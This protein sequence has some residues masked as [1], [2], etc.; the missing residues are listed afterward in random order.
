[1]RRTRVC[2]LI[3]ACLTVAPLGGCLSGGQMFAIGMGVAEQLAETQITGMTAEDLAEHR[4]LVSDVHK[5]V[6]KVDEALVR[7]L[8]AIDARELLATDGGAP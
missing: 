5:V 7:H 4:Q 6:A 1:M 8:A 3:I 2:C